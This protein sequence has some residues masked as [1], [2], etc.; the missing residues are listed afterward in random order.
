MRQSGWSRRPRR[1]RAARTPAGA[2]V[3]P[4]RIST[5]NVEAYAAGRQ[6][7]PALAHV[8]DGFCGACWATLGLDLS[9]WRS[10]ARGCAQDAIRVDGA[11]HRTRAGCNTSR[12]R[13]SV[14]AHGPTW[15]ERIATTRDYPQGPQ[16]VFWLRRNVQPSAERSAGSQRG[17]AEKGPRHQPSLAAQWR[18]RRAHPPWGWGGGCLPRRRR[19]WQKRPARCSPPEAKRHLDK[20]LA[21]G[22]V[23]APGDGLTA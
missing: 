11:E 17:T 1:Q 5:H 19:N 15:T 22:L 2:G 18:R 10:G 9:A 12:T 20:S 6:P 23:E 21:P 8:D 14:Q 13:R 4:I 3:A 7:K 16:V